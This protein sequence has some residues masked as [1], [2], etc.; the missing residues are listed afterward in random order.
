MVDMN[1]GIFLLRLAVGLTLSVHGS[2]MLFGWFGG[3]GLKSTGQFFEERLGFRPGR[4][5][6]FLAGLAE[7]GG[8]LLLALGF[9]MPV[10]A[11]AA[12]SVMVVAVFSVHIQKG[13]FVNNGGYEY[14]LVLAVASLALAF[15]GSGSISIDAL[16][17]YR[18]SGTQW[19]LASLLAGVLAGV[20]SLAQ[21]KSV[22]TAS[23]A[24]TK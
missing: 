22:P 9:L 18:E 13:F 1:I 12:I 17:N 15:T 20:I 11:A 4:R 14:N 8:G 7:A 23:A 3:P 10:G 24:T 19:G 5:H 16:L 2:Q 21:R 6:A